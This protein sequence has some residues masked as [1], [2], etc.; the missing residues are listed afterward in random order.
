[1]EDDKVLLGEEDRIHKHVGH[2]GNSAIRETQMYDMNTCMH[3][4][5][6][7]LAEEGEGGGWCKACDSGPLLSLP[8]KEQTRGDDEDDALLAGCTQMEMTIDGTQ[9]GTLAPGRSIRLDF[10]STV[11]DMAGLVF[12]GGNSNEGWVQSKRGR[13]SSNEVGGGK[14][15]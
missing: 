12:G 15:A 7:N 4:N 2:D 13:A 14:C 6:M 8:T 5:I 10:T 1:M 11:R 9:S 3:S